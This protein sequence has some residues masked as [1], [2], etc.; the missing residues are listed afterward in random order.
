[1]MYETYRSHIIVG[2]DF[3]DYGRDEET[4]LFSQA[5]G[6]SSAIIIHLTFA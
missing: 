1:M 5:L 6:V 2:C 4:V 3:H